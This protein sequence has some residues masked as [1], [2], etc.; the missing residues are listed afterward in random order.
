MIIRTSLMKNILG[1]PLVKVFTFLLA[2]NVFGGN[3]VKYPEGFKPKT[4]SMERF[5]VPKHD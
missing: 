2:T 5:G 1:N 3:G 4:N